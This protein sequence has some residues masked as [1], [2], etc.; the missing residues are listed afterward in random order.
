MV[1]TTDGK[2]FVY[3]VFGADGCECE[4]LEAVFASDELANAH[5]KRLREHSGSATSD[6]SLWFYGKPE[7]LSVRALRV[8][9]E[10]TARAVGTAQEEVKDEPK[11]I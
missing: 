11:S 7:L 8:H 9:G 5:V 2:A 3:G 1:L 6:P 4:N 10:C